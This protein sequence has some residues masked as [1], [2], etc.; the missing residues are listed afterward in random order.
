MGKG[1]ELTF[2]ERREIRGKSFVSLS[3]REMQIT[4][5]VRYYPILI[6]KAIINKTKILLKM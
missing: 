3:I 1:F 6:I 2:I 5:A 4:I